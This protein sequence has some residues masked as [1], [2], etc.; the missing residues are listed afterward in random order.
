MIFYRKKEKLSKNDN[1]YKRKKRAVWLC[2]LCTLLITGAVFFISQEGKAAVWDEQQPAE[3]ADEGRASESLIQE[4]DLDTVQT[5]IDE[6]LGE[7][8][9]S[10]TQA[11]ARLM[12]GEQ[13]FSKEAWIQFIKELFFYQ[14]EV[15]KGMLVKVFLLT[16]TAAVFFQFTSAFDQGQIENISFY[17]LYLLLF[18][19]LAHSF[20]SLSSQ[21]EQNLTVMK[22]FMQGLAPAYFLAVAASTGASSAAVF[23]QMVLLLVWLIQW[24]LLSFVLPA[25]NLYVLLKMI[26]HLSKEEMLSKLAQLLKSFVNWSLKTMLGIVVGM[27]VIQSMVAPVIDSLKRSAVGKTA[28]VIPGVGNAINAVTEIVLTSAVLVR[29]CLGVSFV[30]ILL[31]W[32][33]GPVLQYG[34]LTASYKIMAAFTQ[35]VSD[36]RM[37]GC[38]S[39]MGDGCGMLLRILVTAEVLSMITIA[40]LAVSFG[41]G[42]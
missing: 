35:P 29:N 27:Q 22:N 39:S 41:G 38:L 28:S 21:L 9:F 19:M 3:K 18:T 14:L 30:V 7:G 20:G 24:V 12:S 23:Y 4:M 26:N 33:M 36:V 40:V 1:R 13:P 5:M 8:R 37:V 42:R 2:F 17:V 6:M 25:A 15:Q 10:L 16:V 31:L 34:I 11:L 32:S